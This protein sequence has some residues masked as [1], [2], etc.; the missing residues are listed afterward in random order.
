MHIHRIILLLVTIMA[1]NNFKAQPIAFPGAEGFG[2]FTTGGRGGKVYHVTTLDDS[3]KPG[4]LRYAINQQGSRTVVFDISGTIFLKSKLSIK[5]P[6]ITLAGQSAPGDG[7]CVANYPFTIDA[8][9]VIIR[10]MRFRLGN[11]EVA[12]HEGD[13]LGGSRHHNIIVDHCS[14]SWSIDEC[15]SVYG[16]WDFTIQWCIASQSLKNAGHQKGAHAYGGNWGGSGASYHH[17]LIAHCESRTPRL[18][19]C[20]S[21][22]EDERMD[23]RN[24]VIYNWAAEGCYGGEAMTVN[25]VNNYFKPGPA[26]LLLDS[27]RQQRIAS[28][29]I[30]TS[31][32][33]HHESERPNVWDKM[34]HVWGKFY[35]DGNVNTLHPQVTADNWNCGVYN[36]TWN[37]TVDNTYDQAVRDSIRLAEPMPFAPVTT[38]TAEEAYPLV[39]AEA[40]ASLHRD[41]LDETIV[42]DVRQGLATF[43]G[44]D[45]PP[46]II[47]TQNDLKPANASESWSPWPTLKSVKAPKDTDGDGMPDKWEKSHGLE[48][49]NPADGAQTASNG[50]T[51]LENYLNSLVTNDTK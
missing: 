22:Q 18:G 43:T 49:K 11:G 19:P 21:T 39:L 36:Q 12:H 40:G 47:N 15:I 31:R 5:E 27:L 24:N 29:G 41:A 4:T 45:C 1:T 35:V 7:I 2:R 26:T 8:D 32:Y 23:L 9:N 17:N 30:R 16:N 48:K 6:N 20:P 51:N 37:E 13:G 33:T 14:V 44:A 38:Q 34:W 28:I 25:I 50:Y 10:Y 46:G 42:N 3:D